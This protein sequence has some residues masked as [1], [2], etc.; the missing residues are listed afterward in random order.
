MKNT[1]KNHSTSSLGLLERLLKLLP[2]R[3]AISNGGIILVVEGVMGPYCVRTALD[4]TLLS[5]SL[6]LKHSNIHR[7]SALASPSFSALTVEGSAFTSRSTGLVEKQAVG[8]GGAL[9]YRGGF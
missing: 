2:G 1:K 3:A 6:L 8:P 7:S 5:L 4:A 9:V